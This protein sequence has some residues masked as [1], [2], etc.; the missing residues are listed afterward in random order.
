[1]KKQG[2][3]NAHGKDSEDDSLVETSELFLE[4]QTIPNDSRGFST[5]TG[6][7]EVLLVLQHAV[8]PA[9]DLAARNLSLGSSF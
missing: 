9:H 7:A 6:H 8:N 1:L 5:D 3:S 4:A 2:Q